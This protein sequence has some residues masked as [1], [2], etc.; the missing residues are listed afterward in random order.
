MGDFS[1]LALGHASGFLREALNGVEVMVHTA[2]RLH[3]MNDNASNYLTELRKINRDAT[4]F[5]EF[6]AAKSA[7]KQSIFLS[8][9]KG[10]GEVTRLGH[11]FTPNA[12]HVPDDP[13]GLPK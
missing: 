11:P 4:L 2:A 9:I 3:I 7:I 10:N 5:L 8:S 13:N 12:V 6:F 1:E